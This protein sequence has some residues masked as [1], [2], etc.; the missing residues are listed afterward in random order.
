VG[1]RLA[2][3]YPRPSLAVWAACKLVAAQAP[4]PPSPAPARAAQAPHLAGQTRRRPKPHLKPLL[5]GPP[6]PL[7]PTSTLSG[8]S[9]DGCG[10][11]VPWNGESPHQLERRREALHF[12]A[13]N[14]L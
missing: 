12:T 1:V 10:L 2:P 9:Y 5:P 4:H 8:L 11:P 7:P 6:A 14:L 13:A 3:S